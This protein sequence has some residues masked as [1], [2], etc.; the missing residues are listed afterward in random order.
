MEKLPAN[1]VSDIFLEWAKD[2]KFFLP[3]ELLTDIVN[4]SGCYPGLVGFIGSQLEGI[5][6][7]ALPPYTTLSFE[8]W[9]SIKINLSRRIVNSEQFKRL[10]DMVLNSQDLVSFIESEIYPN[11]T[12]H[13]NENVPRESDSYLE[14]LADYGLLTR[15]VEGNTSTFEISASPIYQMV[16]NAMSSFIKIEP[17]FNYQILNDIPALICDLMSNLDTNFLSRKESWNKGTL[18]PSEYTFQALF[19]TRLYA[20]VC[21]INKNSTSNNL[22]Y[23]LPEG[24]S[25]DSRTRCDL[26]IGNGKRF[27]IELKAHSHY[28]ENPSLLKTE[29]EQTKGYAKE[30]KCDL[31]VLVNIFKTENVEDPK[32]EEKPVWTKVN[33]VMV[34]QVDMTPDF[35]MCLYK[36]LPDKIVSKSLDMFQSFFV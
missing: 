17:T 26:L 10:R 15:S 29:L 35:T 32:G 8:Q 11:V 27:V 23:V 12:W 28:D 3:A 34:F 36:K 18:F 13:I 14:V 2:R 24:K 21:S 6:E 19:F 30:H 4:T 5:E 16:L 33:E 31:A 9:N 22:W 7:S 25:K 1:L 20:I